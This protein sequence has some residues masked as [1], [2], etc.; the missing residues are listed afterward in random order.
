MS[1]SSWTVVVVATVLAAAPFGVLLTWP[2]WRRTRRWR[3]VP[4]LLALHAGAVVVVGAIAVA[5]AGRSWQLVDRDPQEEAAAALLDVSRIDGDRALYAL[6]VLLLVALTGLLT[7]LLAQA[8]RFAAGEDP[9]GRTIACAVLGL[10]I[11]VAGLALAQLVSGDRSA[12]TWLG[13]GHLPLLIA[14]MV[15]CWPPHAELDHQ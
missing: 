6:L 8:A 1:L 14:A 13:V 4:A 3:P 2:V 7:L 12:L 9:G 10:E 5:A 15:A 11:G